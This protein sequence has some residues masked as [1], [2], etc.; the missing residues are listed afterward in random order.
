M[1][2][3]KGRPNYEIF[4]HLLT[5]SPTHLHAC[6]LVHM[7]RVF[8][9]IWCV[10]LL[11]KLITVAS[12]TKEDYRVNGLHHDENYAGFISFGEYN[13]IPDQNNQGNFFFWLHKQRRKGNDDDDGINQKLV[14]WLNG[15]PGCSSMVGQ[16]WENGPFTIHNADEAESSKSSKSSSS[17]S[18]NNDD[19]SSFY[20]KFNEFSWNEVAD[21]IYVEQPVRTGYS[22]ASNNSMIIDNEYKVASDFYLFL[23]EFI[24]IFPEYQSSVD[25]YISGESYA[26]FY[27]PYIAEHIVKTQETM[28]VTD[29]K[30][31]NIQGVAIGN[32]AIDD[33]IQFASYSEYAYS[34]GLIPLG[35]KSY[36]DDQY[37]RCMDR[38]ASQYGTS[39]NLEC[40]TMS[41]VLDAAGKPNEYNTATFVSYDNIIKPGGP[42][43][44]FFNNEKV[45]ELLHVRGYNLPGVNFQPEKGY[46]VSNNYY[47]PPKW[48]VC[49]DAINSALKGTHP[50][51]AVPSLQYLVTKIKVLLY[52]GEFDLNCNTLGT[53]HVLEAHSWNQKRWNS[54]SRGL[55][56]YKNDVA[57][58]HF[59]LDS[60]S[61][62]IVRNS[63]HLLPM[64]LPANALD[65]INRFIYNIPFNDIDLPS[66]RDYIDKLLNDPEVDDDVDGDDKESM[67]ASY[68]S[69][70]V[71]MG[72]IFTICIS[73]LLISSGI[74]YIIR[75]KQS[76]EKAG[77]LLFQVNGKRGYV[78]LEATPNIEMRQNNNV[79]KMNYQQL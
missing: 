65:M 37:V 67:A 63:G 10:L 39:N 31:I 23:V 46:T 3:L 49:N 50:N 41:A 56:K 58:E 34:H 78:S 79:N 44:R 38:T 55:W 42:F 51:T 18:S 8:C 77:S 45:Q 25:V 17:E 53:L 48:E 36:I 72:Q 30:Y 2:S 66:E 64:D 20:L 9:A 57:G 71:G 47:A 7:D 12:S 1:K 22:I 5:Y 4:T 68:H 59:N 70:S 40:N 19:I 61:F 43:F 28:V 60:L 73:L 26:G 24:T 75:M 15:G 32:G 16:L 33:A 69:N 6:L 74:I 21:V 35:A 52:S 54:A 11:S 76:S 14:I 13:K 62:L 29:P 27:I